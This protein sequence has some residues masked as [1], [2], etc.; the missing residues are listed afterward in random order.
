MLELNYLIIQNNPKADVGSKGWQVHSAY[1]DES[2][3][4]SVANMLMMA[5]S[6]VAKMMAGKTILYRLVQVPNLEDETIMDMI[7]YEN[8]I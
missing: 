5:E 7:Y 4:N 2:A 8:N 1:K 3:R 6:D